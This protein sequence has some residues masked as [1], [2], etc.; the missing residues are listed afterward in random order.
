MLVLGKLQTNVLP[1]M[2]NMQRNFSA[3]DDLLINLETGLSTVFGKPRGSGRKDPADNLEINANQPAMTEQE[4]ALSSSL[5]R[6][7]HCG[8]VCA[9][10]LYQ[11]QSLTAKDKRIRT[12]LKQ[13]S[14]EEN[15]HLLWCEARLQEL[16]S[17]KSYLNPVWYASSFIIGLTAGVLGDKWSLGFLAET[18][19]QVGKHL[20]KHLQL[21]SN[22]D[23]KSIAVLKQMSEDEAQHEQTA[24]NSGAHTL[25]KTITL[26][27]QFMSKIMTKTTYYL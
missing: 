16:N 12:A 4:V 18:E 2:Q 1:Y 13:A 22:K 14:L 25:P 8:E 23:T 17:H 6:I 27:M 21:I 3:L 7:N 20:T 11:G 10:A 26:L 19:H 15:D 24:I 9:Q 5:M